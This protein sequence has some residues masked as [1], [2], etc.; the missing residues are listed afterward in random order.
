MHARRGLANIHK[1]GCVAL[2]IV[3]FE[4]LGSDLLSCFHLYYS[5]WNGIQFAQVHKPLSE[6]TTVYHQCLVFSGE[7]VHYRRLHRSRTR[8]CYEYHTSIVVGFCKPFH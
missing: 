7:E 2:T 3:L 8:T 1:K 6:A 4:H 5:V